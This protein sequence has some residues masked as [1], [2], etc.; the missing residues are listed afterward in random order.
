MAKDPCHISRAK[1]GNL[2]EVDTFDLALNPFI[3]ETFFILKTII[4]LKLANFISQ[5]HTQ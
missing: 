5:I 2:T 4:K 3:F 1:I